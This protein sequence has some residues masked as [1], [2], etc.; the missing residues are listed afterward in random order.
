MQASIFSLKYALYKMERPKRICAKTESTVSPSLRKQLQRRKY[1]H[2]RQETHRALV[3]LFFS[4]YIQLFLEK[5]NMI[6][7]H[8]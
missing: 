7:A 4:L 8:M 5:K 2:H 1:K 3:L 6:V